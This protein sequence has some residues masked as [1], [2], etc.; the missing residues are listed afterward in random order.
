MRRGIRRW[1][2]L[3]G[4]VA[5]MALAIVAVVS[6]APAASAAKAS[7]SGKSSS[8]A[9]TAQVLHAVA[10]ATAITTLPGNVDPPLKEAAAD[11][12]LTVLDQNGCDPAFGAATVGK[13]TFGDPMGKKTIVLVG[14]SHAGMWF[15][16]FDTLAKNAHWKLVLLMKAVCPAVDLSFWNWSANS[17]YPACDAFHQYTAN[18]VNKLDP[19]VVVLTSWWHGVGLVPNGQPP[20]DAQWQLGLEQAL[21]SITSPGTKKVVLG[22][23]AYLSQTGPDCLA[24]HASDVQACTTPA[25]DAV[26]SD[27]EQA[28][29]AAAQATG[30]TYISV[31]PW[32][33]TTVCP[34]VIGKYDVYADASEITNQYVSYLEGAL[35]AAMQPVMGTASKPAPAQHK[36]S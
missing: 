16:A 22:D 25:S 15:P 18:R 12:A 33:C 8:V 20:T 7:T 23:M 32:L 30:A 17:A 1:S 10:A 36:S 29:Q 28:L 13:C 19:A 27:H 9:S 6:S 5:A 26:Q 35:A 21:S 11:H 34:A 4:L 24:A 14:D 2:N 31:T 3:G